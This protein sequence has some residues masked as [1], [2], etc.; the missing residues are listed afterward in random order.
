MPIVYD[1]SRGS[2]HGDLFKNLKLFISH[3]VPQR[4]RWIGLVEGN[5]GEVVKLEKLADMLI[6]DHVKR[7]SAAPPPGS[8]SW[9]WIEFSIKNG[10]LQSPDDYRIE[11]APAQAGGTSA[12]PKG[13]GKRVPFTKDDDEILTR[14]VMDHERQGSSTKGNVIFKELEDKH[15]DS[16]HT[17]QSWKDRWVKHLSNRPRPNLPQEPPQPEARTGNHSGRD[18]RPADQ[19][20]Q[21]QLEAT[22]VRIQTEVT[23]SSAAAAPSKAQLTTQRADPRSDEERLKRQEQAKKR[24]RAAKLVPQTWGD[25]VDRRNPAQLEAS[26]VPLQSLIR[27]YLLRMKHAERLLDALETKDQQLGDEQDEDPE[28]HEDAEEAFRPEVDGDESSSRDQFYDDLQDYLEVSGAEIER[29]PVVDGRQIKLWD[30]FSVVTKQDCAAEDRDWKKVAQ[31]LGFDWAESSGCAEDLREYYNHNLADFEEVIGS[32]DN[33]D[34]TARDEDEPVPHGNDDQMLSQTTDAVVA[35]KEPSPAPLSPVYRSSSP[36]AG[37][38]RSFQQSNGSHSDLGY[39]S[40]GPSKRRRRDCGKAIPPTP[41]H[42]LGLTGSSSRALPQDFSSPL[43]PQ[44]AAAG[45]D[46]LYSAN[47]AEDFLDNGMHNDEGADDL[48]ALAPPERK[49][50]FE[51]ETQDFGFVM[52]GENDVRQSIENSNIGYMTEEDDNTPSQQLQSEFYAISSPARPVTNRA[53]DPATTN[54]PPLVEPRRRSP[55]GLANKTRPSISATT[56]T[57]GSA[58]AAENHS[59]P[60]LKAAKRALPQ[61]YQKQPAAP[62]VARLPAEASKRNGI[63][64]PQLQLRSPVAARPTIIAPANRPDGPDSSIRKSRQPVTPTPTR[65]VQSSAQLQTPSRRVPTA[66]APAP[67]PAQGQNK[68]PPMDFGEDYVDAQ[69][70]HF[71]ALGYDTRQIGRALEVASLQR[72]PMTVALQSLHS[73]K[74]IP[75]DAPGVW[76]DDDDEK[77]R[78]VRDHDRRQKM[79]GS[80]G[81]LREKARVDRYR[82]FLLMKHNAWMGHRLAFMDVMDKGS[83]A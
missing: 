48:P 8:Y 81:D 31:R 64:A 61:Q 68:T 69:F 83:D 79:G 22:N 6:A 58:Q 20:P 52:G 63:A 34:D 17:W 5:G 47:D 46:D 9:R 2:S 33:P 37:L 75:Q 80:G 51:P 78:K 4:E 57:N 76:T 11:G 1:G 60:T 28:Q 65:A 45:P 18:T 19:Q 73:G 10:F 26:V 27:G 71:L 43:Q 74:G 67:K 16:G 36:V 50:F 15:P 3:R 23:A 42:K 49:T 39:P 12:P 44:E 25:D 82:K 66:S 40:D 55:R 29:Q 54:R 30:L 35:P 72:G 56:T 41:E 7:G 32:Y 70:E 59:V 53:I 14:F 77:L 13:R 21:P 24:A 62:A 38:K